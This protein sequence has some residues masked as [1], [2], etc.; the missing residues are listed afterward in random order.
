MT[1]P[2]ILSSQLLSIFLIPSPFVFFQQLSVVSQETPKTQD[3]YIVRFVITYGANIYF[4][5]INR[6]WGSAYSKSNEGRSNR[7]RES[8]FRTIIMKK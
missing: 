5:P 2:L 6:T 1:F 8:S 7:N 4:P 3:T